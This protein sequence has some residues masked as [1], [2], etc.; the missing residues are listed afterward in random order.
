MAFVTMDENLSDDDIATL[1]AVR[2]IYGAVSDVPGRVILLTENKSSVDPV[3]LKIAIWRLTCAVDVC[4][5][6]LCNAANE[7]MGCRRI[8]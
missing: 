2:G 4:E 5:I 1:K 8:F 6:E 3:K 7:F